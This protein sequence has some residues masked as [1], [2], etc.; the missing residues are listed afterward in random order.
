M[1]CILSRI[2]NA[3]TLFSHHLKDQQ[4]ISPDIRRFVW[5]LAQGNRR[6]RIQTTMISVA[7]RL[8]RQKGNGHLASFFHTKNCRTWKVM[9]HCVHE[10]VFIFLIPDAP[11]LVWRV[12]VKHAPR[13]KVMEPANRLEVRTTHHRHTGIP[14]YLANLYGS[15]EHEQP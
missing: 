3:R 6:S 8:Q 13:I 4:N 11:S 9:E 10:E 1:V 12:H 5:N 14:N 2:D 15:T 7:C